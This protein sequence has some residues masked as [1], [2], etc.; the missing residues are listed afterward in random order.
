MFIRYRMQ[1]MM[2]C[3]IPELFARFESFQWVQI[4]ASRNVRH[5]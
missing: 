3:L 5:N 4:S 1:S 2:F